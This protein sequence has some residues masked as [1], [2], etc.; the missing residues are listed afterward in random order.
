MQYLVITLMEKNLK[1]AYICM[2]VCITELFLNYSKST[3]FQLRK[4]R[5]LTLDFTA[6][7]LNDE[8]YL[9]DTSHLSHHIPNLC[10]SCLYTYNESGGA[11]QV[12]QWSRIRLQ[13]RRCKFRPWVEK[14]PWR[15]KWQ[16]I[17]VFLPGKSMDRRASCATVHESQRVSHD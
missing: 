7:H 3:I 5:V 11:S 1:I 17:P 14:I 6:L 4:A 8:G 16:L 10:D 2:C 13:Y 12:A 9:R 15:R